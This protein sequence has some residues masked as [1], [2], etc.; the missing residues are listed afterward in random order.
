MFFF[1]VMMINGA[2]EDRVY[3]TTFTE[4]SYDNSCSWREKKVFFYSCFLF[5]V[6]SLE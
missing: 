1:N 5:F 4:N 6:F 3:G 2:T